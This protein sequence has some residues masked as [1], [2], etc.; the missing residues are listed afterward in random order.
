MLI[1][2]D[3][4]NDKMNVVVYFASKLTCTHRLSIAINR[5]KKVDDAVKTVR[6]AIMNIIIRSCR[7]SRGGLIPVLEQLW[8]TQDAMSNKGVKIE[9]QTKKPE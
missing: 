5:K 6:L 9:I 3:K 7:S 8:M 2:D 4:S 1:V